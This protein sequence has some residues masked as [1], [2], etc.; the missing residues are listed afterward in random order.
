MDERNGRQKYGKIEMEKGEHSQTDIH[1]NRQ[2]DKP[3][4][5]GFGK[6]CCHSTF[7]NGELNYILQCVNVSILSFTFSLTTTARSQCLQKNTENHNY[8]VSASK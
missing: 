6:E 7:W 5:Y 2:P 3:D 8:K 4:L 1:T